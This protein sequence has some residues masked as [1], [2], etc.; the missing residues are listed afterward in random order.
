[1]YSSLI[2]FDIRVKGKKRLK[3]GN[4]A[5]ISTLGDWMNGMIDWAGNL[6]RRRF[7]GE[8]VINYSLV[9]FLLVIC[10]HSD[11]FQRI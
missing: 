5:P 10:W 2:I 11:L 1:M 9:I 8:I 7:E 3:G 4:S 6:E